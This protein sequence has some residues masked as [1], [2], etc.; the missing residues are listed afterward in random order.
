[1]IWL[2]I[3]SHS[4]RFHIESLQI[5]A[6][7]LEATQNSGHLLQISLP[8]L[9]WSEK[10]IHLSL[11]KC[12]CQVSFRQKWPLLMN[13]LVLLLCLSKNNKN[14]HLTK[15]PRPA[16][17][18]LAQWISFLSESELW[19]QMIFGS[20]FGPR[21]IMLI[22]LFAECFLYAYQRLIRSSPRNLTLNSRY[23]SSRPLRE[24][25]R[26]VSANNIPLFIAL[27]SGFTLG[28]LR[29]RPSASVPLYLVLSAGGRL[30]GLRNVAVAPAVW[31]GV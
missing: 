8:A 3:T 23:Y 27:I 12:W 25:G 19:S 7:S 15:F 13:S 6:Y 2:L 31:L 28:T 22:L 20:L 29:S 17:H 11:G 14:G 21:C 10:R 26:A 30:E 18:I 9:Y 24:G 4:H 5:P 16:G 1:M